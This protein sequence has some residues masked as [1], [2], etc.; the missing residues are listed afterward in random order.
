VQ[1]VSTPLLWGLFFAAALLA[2]CSGVQMATLQTQAKAYYDGLPE[3]PLRPYLLCGTGGGLEVFAMNGQSNPSPAYRLVSRGDQAD[4]IS[5]IEGHRVLFAYAG[6]DYFFANV[7]IEASHPAKYASDKTNLIRSLGRIA[8]ID[9]G[10]STLRKKETLHGVEIHG[11]YA[12]KID[13]GGTVAIDN[14]FLDNPK[15]VVSVYYLNQGKKQR[16]FQDIAE[17]QLVRKDFVERWTACADSAGAAG[18]Q[19]QPK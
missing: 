6:L 4:T 7:K 15:I 9:S 5:V 12:N 8:K 3:S 2:A 17:F 1:K 19:T 13:A 16:R 18:S 10:R 14:F 11:L